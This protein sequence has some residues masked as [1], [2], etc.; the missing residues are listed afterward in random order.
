MTSGQRRPSAAR[1]RVAAVGVGYLGAREGTGPDDDPQ[2]VHH[3]RQ[4]QARPHR[5]P[6]RDL[7]RTVVGSPNP[8]KLNDASLIT[9]APL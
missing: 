5:Q 2:A 7:L 9:T 3:H 8:R 6:R 1:G 4:A